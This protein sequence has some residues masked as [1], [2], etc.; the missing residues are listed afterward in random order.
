MEIL[1]ISS[2]NGQVK[3]PGDKSIS[4]RSAIISSISSGV[5][6]IEN[7]LDS[8]DC[9]KTLEVLGK[10]SVKIE[11]R[12][13]GITVYG[14]GIEKL[15]EPSEILEVGNSGTT[16]RIISGMLAATGFMSVLSGDSSINNRPM[17]RIIEPLS[18][19]GAKISG[20]HNNTRAPLVIFGNPALK[21]RSFDLKI[22]S[23]QVKSSILLAALHAQG[24]TEISQPDVSRDHTERMLEYF[25]ADIEY[26]GK[27]TRI[28]PVKTLTGRELYI[29]GD[30]SSAAFFIVASLICKNSHT[31]I[32]GVGINPTRSHFIELL[33]EMGAKIEIKN[34]REANNEPVADIETFSS[35]L[36]PIEI[37]KNVIP[38]IIDEIP[39][40][41]VAA[42]FADGSTIIKNAGEL[43]YK[44]SDRMS[45]IVSEFN[46]LGASIEERGDDLV[47][48]GNIA[49]VP[50]ENIVDSFGD[51]RIAMSL[52]IMSLLSAGKVTILNSACIDTS[53][54]T[55]KHELQQLVD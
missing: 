9:L 11:K 19:M 33:Q 22:S 10:L 32:K 27:T 28:K 26:N 34:R 13:T 45:A 3:I 53:F 20:R 1:G 15:K 51:H 43:R 46:K 5:I 30:I 44:E 8:E 24:E 23:A 39:I 41:C 2:I 50:R 16:I 21:G 31:I 38:K 12:A 42:S 36:R 25:G 54:P 18:Q 55:F 40:L 49:L 4:H 14:S 52:A 37:S 29:P 35:V 48:K 17:A 47:I 7:Y 6:P